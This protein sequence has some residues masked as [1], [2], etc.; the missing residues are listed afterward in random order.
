MEDSKIDLKVKHL[1]AIYKQFIWLLLFTI[2]I[3][4]FFITPLIYL[5]VKLLGGFFAIVIFFKAIHGYLYYRLMVYELYPDRMVFKKG[6]FSI[7]TDF[8]E[9]YRVK[10]YKIY[11]SFFM[12]IFS[13]QTI[14]LITSD[15]SNPIIEIKGVK[16]NNIANV[17]RKQ[18]EQLRKIKGV[19]EFD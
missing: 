19:R 15:K 8:L 2:S 12:R 14:V 16:K 7:K 9:L 17:I 3:T 5:E 10:D 1:Y 4:T 13:I 11:Q 18:V 6:V